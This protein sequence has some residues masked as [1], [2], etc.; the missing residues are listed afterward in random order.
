MLHNDPRVKDT[1]QT[2]KCR[3]PVIIDQNASLCVYDDIP[4]EGEACVVAGETWAITDKSP[5]LGERVQVSR[6]QRPR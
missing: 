4:Q 5:E 1:Y 6:W 3:I 2:K